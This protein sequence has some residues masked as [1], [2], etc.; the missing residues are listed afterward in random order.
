M[1]NTKQAQ[2]DLIELYKDRIYTKNNYYINLKIVREIAHIAGLVRPNI[3]RDSFG[4]IR[5]NGYIY[6]DYGSPEHEIINL[7]EFCLRVKIRLNNQ[8][9][10]NNKQ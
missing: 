3:I 9:Q 4:S 8:L 10:I 2:N 5:V 6:H 1:V 7:H